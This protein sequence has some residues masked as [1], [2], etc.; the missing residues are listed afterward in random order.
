MKTQVKALSKS[1]TLALVGTLAL[2]CAVPGA[3][4]AETSPQSLSKSVAYGDLDL[5]SPAGARELY[6]R[7]RTAANVVCKPFRSLALGNSGF[8]ECYDDA[9]AKAVTQINKA[10]LTKLYRSNGTA[11][12]G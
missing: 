9:L 11:R 4:L 2:V 7:L 6:A 12:V 1:A 3:A 10:T 5:D 8:R